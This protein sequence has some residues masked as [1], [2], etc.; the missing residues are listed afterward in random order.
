GDYV[1][2]LTGSD[3]ALSVAV[4]VSI[5]VNPQPAT[6]QAPTVTAGGDQTITLPAGATLAG[7]VSDDGLPT[8]ATLTTTWIKVSGPGTVTFANANDQGTSATFSVAGLY[9]LRLVAT[10]TDKVANDEADIT[11][12]PP[13]PTNVAPTV[14]AGDD[15]SITLPNGATLAGHVSDDGLP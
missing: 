13:S 6:N 2:Q 11:V 7:I 9:T 8:G 12:N 1:L 5:H 14:T 15:V 10:D 3:G 4:D